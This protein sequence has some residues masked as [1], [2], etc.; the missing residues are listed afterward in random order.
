MFGLIYNPGS[1]P[2]RTQPKRPHS[3]DMLHN[4]ANLDLESEVNVES[5]KEAK[6]ASHNENSAARTAGEVEKAD[7][8]S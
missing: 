6:T 5:A 4:S 7:D 1:S 3:C 8:K 2:R